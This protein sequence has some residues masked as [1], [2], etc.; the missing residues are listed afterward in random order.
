LLIYLWS[1]PIVLSDK[2]IVVVVGFAAFVRLVVG[3]VLVSVYDVDLNGFYVRKK[4]LHDFK[5]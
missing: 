5:E 3:F 1:V 4:G 2:A